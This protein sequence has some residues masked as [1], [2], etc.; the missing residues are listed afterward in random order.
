MQYRDLCGEQVSALGFGCMRLPVI[1]G[2]ARNIDEE[3]ATRLL[4][5]AFE[6]GVNYYDTAYP[7]H[8][9]NS[10]RVLGSALDGI[11]DEVLIAT[12]LPP[13]EIETVSDCDRIF[14][15]QL[16]RLQTDRVDFYLLHTL[17]GPF[18]DKLHDLGVLDWLEAALEDGRIRRAGF[19]FHDHVD[20][21]K[22]IIDAWAWDF[23]MIQYNYLDE[24]SQAGTEGLRYAAE[25]GIDVV[26][27]EPLR[28]G[29]LAEPL[30]AELESE[31][32][33]LGVAW[34]PAQLALRWVFDHPEVSCALSGMNEFEQLEEN[35]E[36]A[37]KTAPGSM[38]DAEH[39]LVNAIRE[40]L[41]AN[42]KVDCTACG[43]CLPCPQGVHIPRVFD[44]YNEMALSSPRRGQMGY[45]HMTNPDEWASHCVECGI[46]EEKCPQ[47]IPIME[48]L[49]EAHEA[50]MAED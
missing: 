3:K 35:L 38:D 11:R 16:R 45:R 4:H 26:V 15:E 7:Y 49:A 2:E 6:R 9:G 24:R 27:M 47:H 21:F 19:S 17:I 8:G 23:C 32:R 22:R 5:H 14:D 29:R 37:E 28:G 12:K 48:M 10:E 20:C 1:D 50:L 36:V 44:A 43:Y 18:W 25:R 41:R 39:T 31:R 46:C 13:H 30:P 33:R 40:H 42:T 34:T